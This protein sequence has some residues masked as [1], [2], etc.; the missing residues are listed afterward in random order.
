MIST[1]NLPHGIAVITIEFNTSIPSFELSKSLV[2]AISLYSHL[3][4]GYTVA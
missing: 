2:E 4:R 1:M 3:L